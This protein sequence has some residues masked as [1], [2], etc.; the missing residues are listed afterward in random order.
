MLKQAIQILDDP[1]VVEGNPELK[2]RVGW[3]LLPYLVV[4]SPLPDSPELQLALCVAETTLL[5]QLP[6][7]KGWAHGRHY[8]LCCS[9]NSRVFVFISN[10]TV[11]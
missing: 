9:I 8:E 5:S 7:T 1:R 6:L 11:Y 4:T 3:E 2:A 10:T